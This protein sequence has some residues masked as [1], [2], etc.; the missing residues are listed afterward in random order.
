M[1]G[2]F[3]VA[4]QLVASQQE[5]SSMELVTYYSVLKAKKQT[6]K[7]PSYMKQIFLPSTSSRPVLGPTEPSI[8]WVTGV[9]RSGREAYHSPRASAEIKEMWI[10]TSTPPYA[11]V[12]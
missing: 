10:Y 7:P 3:L 8:Q 12:A 1:L 5:L 11:F 9:K 6:H 4:A 2:N